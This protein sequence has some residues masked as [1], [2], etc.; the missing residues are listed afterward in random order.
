MTDSE[1]EQIR[2]ILG[3]EEIDTEKVQDNKENLALENKTD[4]EIEDNEDLVPILKKD[5]PKKKLSIAQIN[6]NKNALASKRKKK[7]EKQVRAELLAEKKTNWNLNLT[8]LPISYLL[9][10]G[11]ALVG[12]F[13]ITSGKLSL[14]NIR[15]SSNPLSTTVKNNLPEYYT[16][17]STNKNDEYLEAIGDE[18]NAFIF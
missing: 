14:K 10:G 13:L 3:H 15:S 5:A 11:I 2:E 6:R 18:T 12:G 17:Q 16:S 1:L 4:P 8:S 9:V 7:I